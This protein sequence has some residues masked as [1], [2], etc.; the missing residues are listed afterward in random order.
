MN[1]VGLMRVGFWIALAALT[2]SQVSPPRVFAQTPDGTAFDFTFESDAQGWITGFA[3][4]PADFDQEIYECRPS[5]IMGHVRG[6]EN[7]RV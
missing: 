3:D 5:A 2:L 4:L 7:P 6:V 1:R